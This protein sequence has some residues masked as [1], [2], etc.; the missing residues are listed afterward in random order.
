[1]HYDHLFDKHWI[2]NMHMRDHKMST[3]ELA[4]S[5]T[6]ILIPHD[7]TELANLALYDVA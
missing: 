4:D 1:M 6:I 3:T 2:F 5:V 7:T